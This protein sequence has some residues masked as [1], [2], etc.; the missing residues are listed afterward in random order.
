[1]DNF[2]S[3][4]SIDGPPPELNLLSIDINLEALV[5]TRYVAQHYFQQSPGKEK[6]ISVA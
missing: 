6:G 5:A 2:Y 3:A 1:M 4:N